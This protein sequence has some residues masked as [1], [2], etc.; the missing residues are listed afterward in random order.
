[1]AA[2]A[3]ATGP[4]AV[5]NSFAAVE[6]ELNNAGNPPINVRSCPTETANVPKPEFKPTKVRV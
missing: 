2:T 6:A 5:R 1:M 3:I 4:K